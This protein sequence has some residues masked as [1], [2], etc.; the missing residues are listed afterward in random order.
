MTARRAASLVL[1][2]AG[3]GFPSDPGSPDIHI[4]EVVASNHHS[5]TDE[6]G[7]SADWVEVYNVSAETIDLFGYA[8]TDDTDPIT[9]EVRLGHLKVPAGGV[10]VLWADDRPDLG[11][12]HLSFKLSAATEKLLLYGP[13]GVLLERFDWDGL[14]TDIARAR[15]PDGVGA[16][17]SC[18][19]PTCGA[20]NG[21]AC[22]TP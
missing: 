8:V 14:A 2:L 3:C 10:R 12:S 16:I 17:A 6:T 15:F 4:N 21:D 5:C 18:S 22:S 11:P 13:D 19:V 9:D 7:G 1:A 20:K